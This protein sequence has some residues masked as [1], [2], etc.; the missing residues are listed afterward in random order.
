M[1]KALE[2]LLLLS[3]LAI[4]ASCSFK[5]DYRPTYH[6][7]RFPETRTVSEAKLWLSW[8]GSERLMFVRGFLA[9]YREG[10]EHGCDYLVAMTQSRTPNHD[11]LSKRPQH[12][13]IS[14]LQALL[15]DPAI[16]YATSVSA[17]YKTYSEDDDVPITILLQAL[18]FCDQTPAQFH[19]QLTPRT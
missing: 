16:T 12:L 15:D 5:P 3:A 6:S 2:I 7:T 4:A 17:F 19:N 14:D 9:G 8:S 18:V 13:P 10:Y 11:C 1:T